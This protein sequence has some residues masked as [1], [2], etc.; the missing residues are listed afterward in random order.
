M[1]MGKI[2]GG[3]HMDGKIVELVLD[4]ALVV[5]AIILFA[6]L[7]IIAWKMGVRLEDVLTVIPSRIG[8]LYSL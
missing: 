1:Q 8:T 2:K 5:I 3:D 4:V 6:V 7:V